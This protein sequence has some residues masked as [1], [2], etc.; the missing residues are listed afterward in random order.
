MS[1]DDAWD[2][3]A[4]PR[5]SDLV[6]SRDSDRLVACVASL[7]PERDVYLPA[8]WEFVPTARTWRR[9]T[10]T[11]FLA[12][13]PAFLPDGS[14]VCL[15]TPYELVHDSV[16]PDE[17]YALWLLPADGSAPTRLMRWP[18]G[19]SRVYASADSGDVRVAVRAMPG[20]ISAEDEERLRAERK[21]AGLVGAL[22]YERF[23]VRVWGREYS[24]GRLRIM[25]AGTMRPDGTWRPDQRD[26]LPR[27]QDQ[28]GED[29][30]IAPDGSRLVVPLRVEESRG[31]QRWSLSVADDATGEI[32]LI[33][34]EPG[35]DH[36]M[37][38]IGNAARE[39]VCVRRR[40]ETRHDPPDVGL[41]LIDLETKKTRDLTS[42][43]PLWPRD[44]VFSHD[45]ESVYFV[46]DERGRA[47][48]FRVRLTTGE[49][50]RLT[51][52]GANQTL[53]PGR[54]HLYALH[55]SIDRP[56]VPVRLNVTEAEQR[57]VTL[58]VPGTAP[59]LP[60]EVTEV[61]AVGEDGV[62]LRAWLVMPHGP[63]P[64]FP[65]VVWLHGGPMASWNEWS[66]VAN[67]WL[68][69]AEGYAVLLPDHALSTGY[70][71]DFVRRGWAAWGHAPYDDVMALTDAACRR[72]DIDETACA[73]IGNSFGG[74]LAN[75]IATSTRR[76]KAI[77]SGASVWHLESFIA[78][79]DEPWA[80][81]RQWGERDGSAAQRENILRHSPHSRADRL[82]TPMLVIHGDEDYRVPISQSLHLWWDLMRRDVDAK[83]L[84]FPQEDHSVLTP[85]LARI[86][87]EVVRA[88]LDHHLK[89][90]EWDRPRLL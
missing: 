38:A 57:P 15:G 19:I 41:C 75:W 77:V 45:D 74:Y 86:W 53:L 84:Y 90:N 42:G 46:A 29:I 1:F 56:P 68:L 17:P 24:P 23:P 88:F 73:V 39:V 25:T 47:P 36:H 69:A 61:G 89:G 21:R 55:S 11:R 59:R 12:R 70:G 72:P 64:P 9:L 35:V 67:P 31:R 34:D 52:S 16:T 20:A 14:L 7:S 5:V 28:V 66:W 27:V 48:V 6:V 65:L 13:S 78:T 8:L 82:G 87:H 62:R 33:A 26:L 85:A 83:L 40:M 50:T 10:P 49:I 32:E 76:F 51:G 18:T 54:S 22:L 71:R 30:V 58:D 81:A 3:I 79:T 44:P 2:F 60:G 4:V 43:F 80:W 37:P 63:R